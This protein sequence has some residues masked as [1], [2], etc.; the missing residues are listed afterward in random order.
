MSLNVCV[1]ANCLD[2]PQGGG[3]KWVYLN[4]ALGLRAIGCQVIWLEQVDPN[5]PVHEVH[6]LVLSLKAHLTPYGLSEHVALCSR[7]DEPLSCEALA[8]CLSIEAAT[9]ADLLLDF[10]HNLPHETVRK[11]R[12]SALVDIDPGLLQIWVSSGQVTLAPHNTYFTIGETV[13]RSGALFPDLGLKWHYTPPCVALEWWPPHPA[14]A[15]APFTTVA[16]WYANSWFTDDQGSDDKRSGFLPFLD[17]PLHTAQ[18]LELALDLKEG[19]EERA[20]L[21][22]RGWR[23]RDSHVVAAAPW[24]YQ[25]YIQE[26]RGEFSCVKPGCIKLQNAWISDRTICYLASGKPVVIQ[27][28]GP[29]RFLP[30]AAG[31]LRFRDLREAKLCVEMATADYDRQSGFARKL[32]EEYFDARQVAGRV[33]ERAM[34]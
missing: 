15:D 22:N 9:E 28:T 20:A 12:R 2:Y 32:A 30:D 29:S 33:L 26:S 3:L 14:P 16:H 18:P 31:L 5:L 34:A 8:G 19:D 1:C 10:Q 11:F 24:D 13:G 25:H 27:H 21:Q 17:L 23:V 4:W 7:G 6:D